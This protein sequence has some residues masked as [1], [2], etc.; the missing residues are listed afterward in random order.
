MIRA[1]SEVV[2]ALTQV[3]KPVARWRRLRGWEPLRCA[4]AEM[5]PAVAIRLRHD[6]T[7]LTLVG[8]HCL[9]HQ[10][11]RRKDAD[12]RLIAEMPTMRWCPNWSP[13]WWRKAPRSFA[14]SAAGFRLKIFAPN[15]AR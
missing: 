4:L 13:I 6:K 8:A 3:G 11:N 7:I 9:L 15:A 14:I 2:D 1:H 12:G 10:A 5:V